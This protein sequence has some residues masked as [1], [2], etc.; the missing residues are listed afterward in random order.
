[1]SD[2]DVEVLRCDAC[3]ALDPGPRDV[4]GRCH[5]RA[6]QPHRVAGRG[7]LVSWTLI[8]YPP[9]RFED[10]EAYAVAVVALDAGVRVTGPLEAADDDIRPGR[11]VRCSGALKRVPVFE[12]L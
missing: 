12:A 2:A 7:T 6:L 10:E 4:C 8:R 5:A 11:A 1:M 3:G 9:T